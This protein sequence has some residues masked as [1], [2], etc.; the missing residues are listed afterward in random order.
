MV[1]MLKQPA[2]SRPRTPAAGISAVLD[3]LDV[4]DRRGSATLAQLARE[5]GVPKST[6]HRVCATMLDRGWISREEQTGRLGPGPRVA[7]LG[8]AHPVAGLIGD[9]HAVAARL[10][11]RHNETTCLVA[12][13]G[14]E[15]VFVAKVET[16]HPVRLV[17]NVGSRL[18]AFASAAGRVMLADLPRAVVE[19]LLGDCEL[20]TPTGR[21]LAGMAELHGILDQARRRGHAENLDETALGLHCMGAPIGLPGEVIA[22]IT[23]CVPSGRMS[24]ARKSALLPDL[25]LAARELTP[26]ADPPPPT[27]PAARL[28]PPSTL[29]SDSTSARSLRAMPRLGVGSTATERQ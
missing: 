14:R 13:Q 2:A 3:V 19:H 23:L 1:T 7:W 26:M 20:V 9:F 11:A 18:P 22:A 17:T 16:S 10:V 12:L 5:T 6:L 28:S 15:I 27:D 21:R 29:Q 24:P 4:L 8:R 25:L